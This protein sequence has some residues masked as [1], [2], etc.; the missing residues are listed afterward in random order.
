MFRG[1]LVAT[2]GGGEQPRAVARVAG[3]TP[4]A[5]C[6]S[7][8]LTLTE[9]LRRIVAGLFNREVAAY[10]LKVPNNMA[11]LYQHIR[12]GDVVLV[13][14]TL[15]ISQLVKYATQSQWSSRRRLGAST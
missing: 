14:G 2:D 6:P 12:R 10:E 7:W 13:E 4:A 15:R 1:A 3:M 11:R 8:R 9:R 5:A